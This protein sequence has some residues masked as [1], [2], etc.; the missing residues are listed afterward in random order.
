MATAVGRAEQAARLF[1]ASAALRERH[2]AG[3]WPRERE[4]LDRAIAPARA[5]LSETDFAAAWAA[6]RALALDQAIAEAMAV[7]D[8]VT[9]SAPDT[10]PAADGLTPRELEVLRLLAAGRSD[11]EIAAALF[12]SR[13]TVGVHVS[14]I[15]AKLDVPSRG[16]AVAHAHRHGL[17]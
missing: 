5:R 4:R 11:R 6:G 7:A 9:A 14:H 8:T 10:N 16:A 15:L 3:L 2:G 13:K 1:E 17:L 12:I